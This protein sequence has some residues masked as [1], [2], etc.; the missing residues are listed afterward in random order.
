MAQA[1][2][3]KSNN[4]KKYATSLEAARKLNNEDLQLM[5]KMKDHYGSKLDPLY[6]F[7]LRTFI[8][9]Y[10]HVKEREKETKQRI[11][12]Y[13][14]RHNEY[15]FPCILNEP[16][17]NED[18]MIKAWPLYTY[19]YDKQGHPV[20]YDEIGSCVISEVEKVFKND[21]NVLRRYRFRFHRR[22]ANCKRIQSEKY[23]T[24]IFKHVMVMDLAGFSTSH[25]GSNYRNIVKEVIGDEQN[26]FPE[27]LFKLFLI[28]TPFAFRMIWK[29]LGNFV[30]PIT[31]EK[32]HVLGGSYINDMAKVI[33][34]DQIPKKCGGKGMW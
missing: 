6:P 17:K 7:V 21:M 14:D 34:I 5:Q 33:D 1:L 3:Q 12:H 19:G 11:D 31:Y 15:N 4:N 18:K 26:V 10:A 22:L 30:D 16:L 28:N 20:L 32:I 23:D 27:T 2:E 13:L 9:G 24:V 8:T 29:I 25:F